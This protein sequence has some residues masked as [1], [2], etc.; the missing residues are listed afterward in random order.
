M[1]TPL[2][3]MDREAWEK[4]LKVGHHECEDRWFSCPKS[5]EGCAQ[6]FSGPECTCG[7]D[8]HNKR[9]DTTITDILALQSQLTEAQAEVERLRGIKE[10]WEAMVGPVLDFGQ[11]NSEALG[12]RLGDPIM[13]K[14]LQMLHEKARQPK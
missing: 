5:P 8:A 1:I 12:I 11:E 9:M 6:E 14:V 10:Q 7:A 13:D 4:R 3:P 2:N